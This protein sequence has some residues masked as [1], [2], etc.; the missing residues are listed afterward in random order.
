MEI[1]LRPVIP[2]EEFVCRFITNWRFRYLVHG[3]PG[4]LTS[5]LPRCGQSVRVPHESYTARH[6][7]GPQ[8]RARAEVSCVRQEYLHCPKPFRWKC[9]L[10]PIARFLAGV[11]LSHQTRHHL[12]RAE[13]KFR[14]PQMRWSLGRG[15]SWHRFRLKTMLGLGTLGFTPDYNHR[16]RDHRSFLGPSSR[17][18]SGDILLETPQKLATRIR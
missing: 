12:R 9:Q 8:L 4:L 16:S 6:S 17:Q 15:R 7:S 5:L 18:S 13:L 10:L 3:P 11:R 2:L 1:H 14:Q